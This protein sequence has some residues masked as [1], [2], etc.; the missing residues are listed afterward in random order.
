MIFDYSW[1]G[2]K[3]TKLLQAI[4]AAWDAFWDY[5]SQDI[6]SATFLFLFLGALAVNTFVGAVYKVSINDVLMGYTAFKGSDLFKYGMKSKWNTA[7]H[8]DPDFKKS[9]ERGSDC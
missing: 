3:L 5:L 8:E 7:P 6:I 9:K 2:A 1:L 4:D